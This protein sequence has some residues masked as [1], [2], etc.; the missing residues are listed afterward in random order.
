MKYGLNIKQDGALDFLSLGALNHR[1]DPGIIPFR[2]G[3]HLAG[4]SQR[5]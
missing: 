4:A 5:R 3:D 1:V 2:Q